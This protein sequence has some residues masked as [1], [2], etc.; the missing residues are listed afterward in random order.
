MLYK[1]W[2]SI[3]EVPY[4]FKV[5]R[6]FSRSHGFKNRR[7]WLE[8][9]I[10]GLQ[11]KFEFTNGYEMIHKAWSGIVEVPYCFARSS[12]KFQGRTALKIAEFD[13]NWAFPDCNSNLSSLIG[14]K[15]Y[16]KLE[17]PYCLARSSVNF[18]GYTGQKIADFDPNWAFPD[19][20]SRSHG[21]NNHQIWPKL[22]VS[23]L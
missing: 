9:S 13:P 5:I 20:N 17:V 1:A 23:G 21:S 12:L 2:S 15:W 14:M 4:C 22:G 3:E 6:N 11:L 19:C 8:L 18:Q 16:R 7:F 10:S